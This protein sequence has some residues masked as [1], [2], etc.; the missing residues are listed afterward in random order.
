MNTRLVL[1]LIAQL[2]AQ[3]AII[4]L[5]PVQYKPVFMAVVAVIGVL[6]AFYD[7]TSYNPP[8]PPTV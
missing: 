3:G 8:I 4:D 6:V 1:H 2:V 5:V 7:N